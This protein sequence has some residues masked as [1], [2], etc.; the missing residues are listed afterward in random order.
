MNTATKYRPVSWSDIYQPGAPIVG[1]G[2]GR[3]LSTERRYKPVGWHGKVHPF[4]T[5][6]EAQV[7]C[8][9]LNAKERPHDPR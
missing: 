4:A 6:S 9:E 3:K 1:W 7:V 5:K 8:D 2:I